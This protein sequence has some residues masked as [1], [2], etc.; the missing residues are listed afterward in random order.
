MM[1]ITK[2]KE[3]NKMGYEKCRRKERERERGDDVYELMGL[4]RCFPTWAAS[5]VM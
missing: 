1:T 4:T 3:K 2:G 5:V